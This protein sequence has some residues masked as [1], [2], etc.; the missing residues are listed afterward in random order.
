MN[1]S[2]AANDTPDW[3]ALLARV[4]EH[5]DKAAFREIY[6]HFAPRIKAYAI[7]QGFSQHAEVLVQE[8]MTSVWRNAGKYSEALASVSTWIFTITRNQRIDMLRKLNRTRAEVVIETEDL[9]QIPTED[10]TICSIQNLSTEKFVK[11]AIDKLPEEQMIA[12][13]KVY[14]EGKTH[15]EV[16]EELKIPLGTVK[17]RLRLSLQKLRVMFEAKEL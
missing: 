5:D 9:W 8:V 6:K 16:A 15:E 10:T 4:A 14:Y 11:N 1:D 17:G 12:L 2:S 7:N 3:G 13:R